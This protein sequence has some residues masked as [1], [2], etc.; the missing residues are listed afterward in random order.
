[1]N[2][3]FLYLLYW[4][5]Y[6]SHRT[7][8]VFK[9][10]FSLFF[11]I[12]WIVKHYHHISDLDIQATLTYATLLHSNT[13]QPNSDT[14]YFVIDLYLYRRSLNIFFWVF[15]AIFLLE[16]SAG[17]FISAFFLKYKF[18]TCQF[19]GSWYFQIF[20]MEKCM[21]NKQT[22]IFQ[23]RQLYIYIVTY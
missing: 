8:C 7:T 23:Y 9:L 22:I 19:P 14:Q 16:F 1:M 18:C 10:K 13:T 2:Y 4:M 20:T 21:L 6:Q 12:L 15:I 3:H 5:P 17:S 11:I